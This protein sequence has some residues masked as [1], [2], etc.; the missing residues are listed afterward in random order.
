MFESLQH[1]NFLFSPV[2]SGAG[3]KTSL[4]VVGAGITGEELVTSVEKL[5]NLNRELEEAR[6][7]AYNLLEDAQQTEAQL[8]TDLANMRILTDLAQ[9]LVLENK[10]EDDLRHLLHAAISITRADAGTIQVLNNETQQL[11]MV[12]S[13]GFEKSFTKY[14]EFVDATSNTSCGIALKKN[15]RTFIDFDVAPDPDGSLKMH[16]EQGFLSAQSTPLIAHSGKT[17]G[18]VTTHFKKRRRPTDRESYFIDLVV[19]QAVDMIERRKTQE[20]LHK[21]EEQLRQFNASLEQR[22]SERTK[23][24][25]KSEKHAVDLSRSLFVMNKELNS[26]NSELQTFTN[27]AASTYRETLRHLYIS[28]EMIVTQDARNLSNSSR[29][30]LR[31][32]QGAVQKMKLLTEDLITFSKLHEIGQKEEHI[33]LNKILQADIN[34]FT[35]KP[36][37]PPIEIKCD[38]LPP[39]SGYPSLLS[40]LF[41]HLLDNAIKFRKADKDHTINITC[42]QLENGQG[43]DNESVIKNSGYAVITVADNGIGFHREESEKIF[44]M[45]YQLHEKGKYKGSG[46]GLAVCKKI[47]EM[48]GG[49]ITAEGTPGEG[50]SFHCY[51]PA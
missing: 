23:E 10:I 48:H 27:I 6:R 38:D 26:L 12:A 9:K 49:F 22:V 30:N 47:M 7:A 36:N 39:I 46:V 5:K 14:F 29:A 17:I 32:S 1:L 13:K 19:R 4:R 20:A 8:A 18:M 2:D 21:S 35:S 16:L 44:E 37:H 34:D 28:L 40:L 3:K 43:L 33:D 45:F 51:F 24:L 31:R 11:E 50:A 25:E 15:E 41:H 42:E